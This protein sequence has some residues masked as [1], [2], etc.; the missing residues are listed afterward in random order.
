MESVINSILGGATGSG[1]YA[2]VFLVLLAC[3]LGVPLPEDV[4]LITGGYLVHQ[5]GAKLGWMMVVSFVGILAG[6]SMIFFLGRYFGE[7]LTKRWPFKKIVT[8][9]KRTK[10]E[11]LFAKHGERIVMIA[12]FMPGV[13]AVTYFCAGTAGMRYSHFAFFDGLAALVSAP[14]FVFLGYYFGENI[15]QLLAWLRT[16]Q[17][18][19]FGTLMLVAA[20]YGTYWFLKRRK[21]QKAAALAA[22]VPVSVVN[23]P[24]RV[25]PT[26]SLRRMGTV[27]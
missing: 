18:A 17:K 9:E 2:L 4:A 11:G 3:G 6:D 21:Q 22:P 13:R 20:V 12:R 15:E 23:E 14:V 16:G 1:A 25:P 7:R 19:V 24:P 26:D 10:V 8:P 5:G 27:D